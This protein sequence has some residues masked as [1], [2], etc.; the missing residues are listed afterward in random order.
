MPFIPRPPRREPAPLDPDRNPFAANC[1]C[2][3][4]RTP[5]ITK[6]AAGLPRFLWRACPVCDLALQFPVAGR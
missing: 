6:D 2:G 1:S 5:L 4:P 3:Q